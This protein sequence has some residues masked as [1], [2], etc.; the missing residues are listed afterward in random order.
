MTNKDYYEEFETELE[1]DKDFI[2][3]F[4]SK[5]RYQ[6]DGYIEDLTYTEAEVKKFYFYPLT[7]LT[8]R[9]LKEGIRLAK[10]KT[11]I[12]CTTPDKGTSLTLYLT[13]EDSTFDLNEFMDPANYSEQL[14]KNSK[15]M[16]AMFKCDEEFN[17][18]KLYVITEEALTNDNFDAV[19]KYINKTI[20]FDSTDGRYYINFVP[21]EEFTSLFDARPL[22]LVNSEPISDK[23]K[24]ISIETPAGALVGQIKP[25]NKDGRFPKLYAKEGTQ[26]FPKL[27]FP[28]Q[29]QPV[30]SL[31]DY[32][33][34]DQ[35][36]PLNDI[37]NFIK[38]KGKKYND[39]FSLA[40]FLKLGKPSEKPVL[41]VDSGEKIRFYSK[42]IREDGSYSMNGVWIPK[43]EP[44]EEWIEF[45]KGSKIG[46][47]VAS[48]NP[49][50][51][52]LLNKIIDDIYQVEVTPK[53]YTNYSAAFEVLLSMLTESF[54]KDN[55]FE[56]AIKTV[57]KDGQIIEEI[58]DKTI[59]V[60]SQKYAGQDRYSVTTNLWLAWKKVNQDLVINNQ[61][62]IK[63]IESVMAML[64]GQLKC[65]YS[66]NKGDNDDYKIL[67]PY[68]FELQNPIENPN[69]NW[70]EYKDIIVKLKSSYFDITASEIKPK[71]TPISE[72]IV[73]KLEY[74][75]YAFPELTKTIESAS[76][77][78]S[79]PLDQQL[80]N[81]EYSKYQ[82][83]S[84]SNNKDD[85]EKIKNQY[86]S[87]EIT[88][89]PLTNIYI[90][91]KGNFEF[92]EVEAIKELI[93]SSFYGSGKWKITLMTEANIEIT[94]NLNLFNKFDTNNSFVNLIL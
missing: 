10:E 78:S 86:G 81:G 11:T 7:T 70:V 26:V 27:T 58:D 76:I 16:A 47:K 60:R 20:S 79:M 48:G 29:T 68:Y 40:D 25:V 21:I 8:G 34:S 18:D 24:E 52:R 67:L 80:A 13:E 38:S 3:S 12:M 73:H 69:R 82:L 66:I 59:Y 35:I 84:F 28:F 74:N 36:I 57:D 31:I 85:I 19:T 46:Y 94:L 22:I 63:R 54:W 90:I 6:S 65:N 75:H 62:I 45:T 64:S 41:R 89:N 5:K 23:I 43:N 51:A 1:E 55:E 32:W 39:S 37:L 92:K 93:I 42:G 14:M 17:I 71:L 77:P 50:A 72:N 87:G 53:E 15:N 49:G 2:E 30:L 4:S 61:S 9:E 44:Y 83:K 88:F 91:N 56:G 33:N